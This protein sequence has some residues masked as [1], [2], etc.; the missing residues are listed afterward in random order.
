[1]RTLQQ[2]LNLDINEDLIELLKSDFMLDRRS[3]ENPEKRENNKISGFEIEKVKDVK[4]SSPKRIENVNKNSNQTKWKSRHYYKKEA[5]PKKG[6]YK[7][8]F[9]QTKNFSNNYENKENVYGWSGYNSN[10]NYQD[11]SYLRSE[12]PEKSQNSFS[13]RKEKNF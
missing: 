3:I 10:S 7:S 5:L 2:D 12:N 9:S 11:Y 6:I 13:F 4:A 8:Q 1:M